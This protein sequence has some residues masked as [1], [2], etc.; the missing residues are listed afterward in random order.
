M[1]DAVS[2]RIV[3]VFTA[4]FV[5]VACAGTACAASCGRF[6]GISSWSGSIRVTFSREAQTPYYIE[7]AT[8][9]AAYTNRLTPSEIPVT[10]NGYAWTWLGHAAGT[11]SFTDEVVNADGSPLRRPDRTTGDGAILADPP[12]GTFGPEQ[13]WIDPDKCVYAFYTSAAV[14]ATHTY[15]SGSVQG[16]DV[17]VEGI[18]LPAAGLTLTG[19]RSYPLPHRNYYGGDQFHIPCRL[20]DWCNRSAGPGTGTVSWSFA[21]THVLPQ[22]HPTPAPHPVRCPNADR[23]GNGP[24][25]RLRIDFQ[26]AFAANGFTVPLHS[27]DATPGTLPR[28]HV[29]LDGL[30]DVLPGS[31]CIDEAIAN[32]SAGPHSQTG[33]IS[34]VTGTVQQAGG[35]TRVTVREVDVATGGVLKSGLGDASGTGDAAIVQAA[36]AAIGA[37]GVTLH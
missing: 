6:H 17:H 36:A 24:L 19:S 16:V 32:G 5:L 22:P 7:R 33:A 25:D 34:L 9:Q 2:A 8:G 18:P 4:F 21:P 3:A 26:A 37:M 12:L 15:E 27:I 20:T 14:N 1:L 31:N 10:F 23:A 13:L 29:R 28:V 35:Q 11:E 30:D